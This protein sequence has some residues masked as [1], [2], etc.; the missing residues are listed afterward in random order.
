SLGAGRER[1]LEAPREAAAGRI[2][3]DAA[4]PAAGAGQSVGHDLGVAELAR[5][6]ARALE[7]DAVHHGARADA[8][9]DEDRDEALDAAARSETVLPPGGSAH[10]ILNVHGQAEDR[11][12]LV[13]ERHVLPLEVWSVDDGL[14]LGMDLAGGGDADAG[15]APGLGG[16]EQPPDDALEVREDSRRAFPGL[17]LHLEAPDE[18][19]LGA[20]EATA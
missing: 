7:Q 17:G 16:V 12:D 19:S 20:Q 3:L 11:L 13:A 1:R 6:I 4:V 10:V 18:L 8:G 14:A 15:D 9:A 2:G 5:R